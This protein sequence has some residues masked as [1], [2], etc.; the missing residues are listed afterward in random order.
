[1]TAAF[2]TALSLSSVGQIEHGGIPASVSRAATLPAPVGVRLPEVDL[3]ALAAQDAIFDQDKSIPYR[4]GVNRA[5]AFD[6]NN[7]GA[8][9]V[10]EDGTRLWRFG[11]ECP[12]ALSINFEFDRFDIPEGAR[13]FVVNAAGRHIGAF[14]RANDAG[15]HVLGVQPMQGDRI[16][17]EYQVPAGLPQGELRIGQ[18]THGYRDVFGYARGLGDSGSCNNNVICPVGDAW[19]D[20]IR[21]VAMIVV[22]GGGICTGTL[23]NNCS[24]DGT[25]YFLTANH[26]LGSNVST[27]VFRFNWESSSCSQN[28]NGPTNQT[29]SGATQL[30]NSS[31]SDVAL[32]QLN[33]TPP[34]SYNVFYSGWD[35]GTAVPSAAVGI[36]HP[37]GDIKKIS[38]E[39]DPL[40]SANYLGNA[41]SGTSHWRVADW[42]D[43]TTEG[44][45]SGSALFNPAGHIIGQL[46][47]GYASCSSQTADYYGRFNVSYP[48]IQS[49]LGSCG[50]AVEGYD[51]NAPS[52]SLDA[53]VTGVTGV[54]LNTCTPSISPSVTVRN[55]GTNVLTAFQL[56]W[57]VGGGPSGAVPWSGSLASGASVQVP[58]GSITLPAGVLTFTA[59]VGA[60]NGGSDQNTA[61]DQFTTSVTY[62]TADVTLDLVL[63]RYGE[64]TTWRVVS[65]AT[66]VASGGPFTNAGS[67]GAYPL[68]PITLC[69]PDGC[70]DL[71]VEDS[72]GDG[73]CCAYGNGGYTL[74]GPDASELASGGDFDYSETTPFCISTQL[75]LSAKAF[76]EGPYSG[77]LMSDGLRTGGWLPPSE[78]Y[79]SLGFS[80]VGGGGETAQAGVFA[81]TGNN[82]IV[83][84]VFVELRSGAPGYPVV[85]TRAALLQRDGDVVDM[86]G[87]SPV[88]FNMPAGNYHVALRHRN[89]LGV[90]TAASVALS[91]TTTTVDLTSAATTT[92]GTDAR[93]SIGAVRALWTGEV[94]RDGMVLYT[95]QNNDRD[96]LL[97]RVG[98]IVPTATTNGYFS[99]DLNMDGEVKYTGGS[100]DRDPIL[101]NIGGT[102]PTAS[103]AEQLP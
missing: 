27:W 16:V 94:V 86:D 38:F 54:P 75:L 65:G 98:G 35:K 39:N 97:V 20:Q 7:A 15:D 36:H 56:S 79:T 61:N 34:A 30:A 45:S 2:L 81:V 77:P 95:G 8:W 82:A 89:H 96:Q 69:L 40:S 6:L 18:V 73:M 63:D 62:G 31:N 29:V 91:G 92:Y 55:G 66:V 78:P 74:T 80:H 50:D 28:L 46:H 102:V 83:D 1:M 26:C 43:G 88:A 57:S 33:S 25:P 9:T 71:I 13:V 90:M 42:D 59:S 44:G 100:N 4:F 23:I 87:L 10:L 24:D 64:E 60:P 101:V 67:S 53:Q 72:Y 85:A 58:L 76:L 51:P 68:A 19:R 70:F 14:T 3:V 49:W 5:T 103:R 21:S 17:V 11:I 37:S 12:D 93:K 41:G 22:G 32:L 48:V 84:W 47:G 99:E 52:L